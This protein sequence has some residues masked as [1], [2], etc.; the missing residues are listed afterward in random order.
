[1]RAFVT[2]ASGFIGSA[3]TAEL[4]AAGHEVVGLARSE[5]SADALT[6]LGAVPLRGELDDAAVLR[7]GAE[8]SDGVV[9]LGFKHDYSD[10]EASGRTERAAVETMGEALAESGRPFLFASGLA[11]IGPG[12]VVT[13]NDESPHSGPDAPRG[14]AE[15]LAAEYS[16]RGVRTV[17]LRFAPS[18]HGEGDHGFVAI[19]AG[20]ARE[21]G[22]A[23]YVGDGENRWPAVNRADAA[24]LVRLALENEAAGSAVH[25]VDEQGIPTREIA[26]ALG[27]SLGVPTRSVAP[28]EAAAHFG[29]LARF[30]GVDVPASSALTRKRLGWVPTHQGLL[31]DIEAGYY[32]V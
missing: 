10:F 4:V 2:G 30:Y 23:G 19:L 20:I 31:A 6:R 21:H 8:S 28:E 18:V 24:V 15:Q 3:V 9:H 12:R 29:F 26:E 7:A 27:R 14:G 5:A 17:A 11:L 1:M 32:A 16:A 13:E 22:F 25:A